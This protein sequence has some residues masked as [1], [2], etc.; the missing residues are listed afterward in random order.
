MND[1]GLVKEAGKR[2]EGKSGEEE[3]VKRKL[4]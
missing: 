3:S 2:V 4:P 1:V